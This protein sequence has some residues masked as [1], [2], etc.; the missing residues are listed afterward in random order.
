MAGLAR[1]QTRASALRSPAITGI[2]A[3]SR[4]QDSSGVSSRHDRALKARKLGERRP[5]H[6]GMRLLPERVM[7]RLTPSQSAFEVELDAVI[8][9]DHGGFTARLDNVRELLRDADPGDRG[10]RHWRQALPRAGRHQDAI[11]GEG[12]ARPKSG[13]PRRACV[14]AKDR[15]RLAV[16]SGPLK[17]FMPNE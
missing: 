10:I 12:V 7:S 15:Q 5:G 4:H 8:G 6:R 9:D 17:H 1:D 3:P 16:G 13:C 11:A 2:R 14:P